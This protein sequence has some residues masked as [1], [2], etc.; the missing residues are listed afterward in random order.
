MWTMHDYIGYRDVVGLST[1][2]YYA[3]PPCGMRPT[4]KHFVDLRKVVDKGHWNYFD[5]GC[6]KWPCNVH[7]AKSYIWR[8]KH[9]E[10]RD[11]TRTKTLGMKTLN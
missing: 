5:E 1:S 10:K 8:P 11:H 6:S 2:G 9:W 3:C 7:N 4:S